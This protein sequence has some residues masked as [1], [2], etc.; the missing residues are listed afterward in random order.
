MK[1]ISF[2]FIILLLILCNSL[3][4]QNFSIGIKDGM[5]WST[6]NGNTENIE[7]S[8][9][10]GENFGLILNYKISGYLSLQTE[11]NIEEKGVKFNSVWCGGGYYGKYELKYFTIPLLAN[12]E[13]GKSVKYYG[14]LGFYLSLLASA[15]NQ[16]IVT[17]TASPEFKRYDYSHDAKD[18][19][20]KNEMGAIVGV[21]IK[22][23]L[24]DRVKFFIETRYNIG[25]C[26]SADITEY[27][28][29]SYERSIFT[30]DNFQN[31]YNRSIS[32]NLG[33]IYNFKKRQT[34]N[35]KR[36]TSNIKHQTPN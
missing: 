27:N 24:C 21:G 2:F 15:D 31:V 30:P 1:K 32:I 6:I 16:T 4:A 10:Q 34:S 23:P 12:F 13:F 3:F 17:S 29:G 18:E 28:G 33:I 35:I 26:N 8:K 19:F 25:L 22:I 36:Q 5:N 9:L 11:I 20:K 14:Y 7:I